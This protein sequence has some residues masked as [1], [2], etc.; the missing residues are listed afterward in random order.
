[1]AQVG[2]YGVTK[3]FGK[4]TALDNINIE[5]KDN[6]FFVLFGPAG[7]GKTTLLNTIAGI[8]I[9]EEG[10]VKFDGDVVN[11]I[12]ASHRNVAMVFENYALYPNQTVYENI[13]SP[14]RSPLYK[15]DNETIDKEVRRIAAM[16]RIDGLLG[17]LPHQISNGQKQR[18]AIGRA[19]IRNPRVMLMDEPL[20]HLDAKLR[21]YMRSELKEMQNIF[22]STV[23]YVTHDYLE[24]ISLGDRIG[25]INEG[26]IIQVGTRDE[27]Y[28]TP[29]NEFVAC[30]VGEPEINIVNG[31]MVTENDSCYIKFDVKEE[32]VPLPDNH[33]LTHKL[34]NYGANEFHIGF[35]PQSIIYSFEKMKGYMQ[36]TVYNFESIGNK[37]VLTV[38]IGDTFLRTIAPYDLKVELDQEVYVDMPV[39][40]G[41]FFDARTTELIGT[42]DDAKVNNN[43]TQDRV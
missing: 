31:A 1:V 13:A 17:R 24:A 43:G 10:I 32:L 36:G 20:A 29:C 16:L 2:M 28:Y 30:L 3:R 35:R 33:P 14:L 21:H 7:A 39:T 12:D 37:A 25:I 22:E 6:E 5:I 18:V 4:K 41:I 27:I 34:S 26:K 23:I 15:K 8:Y 40:K 9:P 42:F 38:R 19:L 11:Q